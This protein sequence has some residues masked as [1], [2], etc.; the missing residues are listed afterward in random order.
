MMSNKTKIIF[1][2]LIILPAFLLACG[3]DGSMVYEG[4]PAPAP[5]GVLTGHWTG[6]WD[7]SRSSYHGNI[8]ADLTQT[9]QSI[10]G[11][12][13]ITGSPCF[14]AGYV[15]GSVGGNNITFGVVSGPDSSS[16]SGNYSTTSISGSYSVSTGQCAGDYGTFSVSK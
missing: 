7:S 6:L 16:F 3:G 4:N 15:T 13:L 12:I 11:T 2:S 9:D 10:K 5:T 8:S 14:G 1:I